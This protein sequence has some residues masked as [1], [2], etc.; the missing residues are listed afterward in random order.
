[1]PTGMRSLPSEASR[2]SDRVVLPRLPKSTSAPSLAG[3]RSS[4]HGGT[5][6]VLAREALY[7]SRLWAPEVTRQNHERR[8]RRW[9]Q[10]KAKHQYLDFTDSERR[11]LRRYFDDMAESNPANANATGGPKMTRD[12]LEDMMISLGVAETRQEICDLVNSI[13]GRTPGDEELDFDDYLDIVRAKLDSSGNQQVF[14]AM[15]R[16]TLGNPHLN[17]ETVLSEYRRAKI[18]NAA[19]FRA[20][21][22]QSQAFDETSTTLGATGSASSTLALSRF[23]ERSLRREMM[24][25]AERRKQAEGVR[26]LSNF[27]SLQKARHAQRQMQ[28]LPAV[29]SSDG[30]DRDRSDDPTFQQVLGHAPLG[31]LEWLWNTVVQDYKIKTSRPSSA[32]GE[33]TLASERPPSPTEVISSILKTRPK[34]DRRPVGSGPTAV[35]VDPAYNTTNRSNPQTPLSPS[36]PWS[37]M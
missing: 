30:R 35:V 4:L 26:I 23:S 22:S 27:A 29:S 8:Q 17:F 9:L 10:R 12:K 20:P 16:G 24:E 1:M 11:E 7:S 15:M 28:P 37:S 13:D 34:I 19:G 31:K 5:S 21:D 36:S 25:D 2:A 18:I 14:K 6:S 32:E 3:G 33:R